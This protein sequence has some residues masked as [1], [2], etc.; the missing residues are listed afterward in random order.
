[1]GKKN[2]RHPDFY[3][4]Y[5]QYILWITSIVT[6]TLS[7]DRGMRRLQLLHMVF[8]LDPCQHVRPH[9][10]SASET[11]TQTSNAVSDVMWPYI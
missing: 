6:G 9:P 2:L 7:W 11:G 1:V 4:F 3:W 8:D 10:N 5:R